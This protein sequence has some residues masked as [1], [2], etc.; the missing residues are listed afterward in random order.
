VGEIRLAALC[1][2]A[3]V[4][5]DGKVSLLG[6]FRNISVSGLPAQHPRMFLV[7]ILGLDV[8]A[9]T[10][11]V[12][13]L[14]PDGQQAMPTTGTRMTS[15]RR[16]IPERCAHRR[17]REQWAVRPSRRVRWDP[18]GPRRRPNGPARAT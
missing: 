13:L 9:H 17:G 1:D 6:I 10:V 12:R 5:Q 7:A 16:T 11:V 2:H 14:R 15:Q 8:G 3:L 4:G 18:S